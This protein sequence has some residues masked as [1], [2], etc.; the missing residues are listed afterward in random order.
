MIAFTR[1]F[2]IGVALA[3]LVVA[4]T[5]TPLFLQREPPPEL[6]WETNTLGMFDVITPVWTNTVI[7]SNRF[8]DTSG[9][10]LLSPYDLP[11]STTITNHADLLAVSNEMYRIALQ[12]RKDYGTDHPVIPDS[13][14]QRVIN[15]LIEAGFS[16]DD[17]AEAYRVT[18]QFA[19]EQRQ[20]RQPMPGVR[21]N[22]DLKR[23][24][25]LG[26]E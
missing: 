16:P 25:L 1:E 22:V 2:W 4:L 23:F 9:R 18:T 21:T 17:A 8:Y 10:P 11:K 7:S 19:R 12:Y 24:P 15:E 5:V 14:A 3:A 6:Q 13:D 20:N 26:E